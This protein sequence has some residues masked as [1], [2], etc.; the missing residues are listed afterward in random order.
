MR[1]GSILHTANKF[2][3]KHT[4][5]NLI[6]T[7]V[8]LKN[9]YLK[10]FQIYSKC[11]HILYMCNTGQPW[12]S[13]LNYRALDK[14]YY[15]IYRTRTIERSFLR[16][17]HIKILN[18]IDTSQTNWVYL[19]STVSHPPP[20]NTFFKVTFDSF[21]ESTEQIQLLYFQASIIWN[22]K[23]IFFFMLQLLRR[24]LD[25]IESNYLIYSASTLHTP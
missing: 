9:W 14:S 6:R 12:C 11:A 4:F 2:L 23:L 19:Y 1:S 15:V 17:Y 24:W 13:N 20:P 18:L 3:D 8:T 10:S 25:K 21:S 5:L 22:G 7:T 16:I